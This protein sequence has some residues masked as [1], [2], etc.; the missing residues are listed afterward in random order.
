MCALSYL[1]L[2][3]TLANPGPADDAIRQE[4]EFDSD[5]RQPVQSGGLRY[6]R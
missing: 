4:L 3:F 6:D 2:S 1:T 5:H